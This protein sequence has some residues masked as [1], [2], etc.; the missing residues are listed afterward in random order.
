MLLTLV[1]AGGDS[2]FCQTLRD[3]ER[4][5]VLVELHHRV[6]ADSSGDAQHRRHTL[7]MLVLKN[8]EFLFLHPG[9][10]LKSVANRAEN[11]ILPECRCRS[12][13]HACGQRGSVPS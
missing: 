1:Q 2:V 11:H 9:C 7:Q 13:P 4:Q 12:L 5:Q 3:G 10:P 8:H 6:A